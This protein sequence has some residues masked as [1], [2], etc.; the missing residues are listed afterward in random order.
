MVAC[1]TC[2]AVSSVCAQITESE[3]GNVGIKVGNATPLSTLSVATPG[4][5][6]VTV[7][8]SST[9]LYALRSYTSS[10]TS[11]SYG[12][13]GRALPCNDKHIGVY[14]SSSLSS[15][16][17]H[18]RAYGVLGTAGNATSGWNYGVFGALGGTN[19]GAAVLGTVE[20][21]T[22]MSWAVPGRYAGYF[23][24]PVH[25]TGEMTAS[26]FTVTS[27]ARLKREVRELSSSLGLLSQLVPVEY[28]LQQ[29]FPVEYSDTMQT[30]RAMSPASAEKESL[31][32]RYGLIAQ[33]VAE[34]FPDIVY[35]DGNGYLSIDYIGLIPLL[36]QSVKELNE[37]LHNS[38]E[39]LKE[40]T[41]SIAEN[42]Y[43]KEEYIGRYMDLCSTYIEKMDTYRRQLSKIASTSS[44]NELCK[45]IKSS[46]FI[47]SE[48][49]EFYAEFDDTFLQLF[50]TFVEDF[51]SLLQPQ[52]RIYPKENERMN[53]ELRIFALIRL[54]ITD[55][56]KIAH[57]LRYSVTTIY[58]YRTKVRNKAVG[59]RDELERMVAKIGKLN[60]YI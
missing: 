30:A 58:N 29:S 36:I 53:T 27:D 10:A 48:L 5:S 17:S 38:N 33:D 14:G 39:K 1:A 22:S 44:K 6:P 59:S 26:A 34:L 19:N 57:F 54:G 41:H 15:P 60:R 3:D 18:Y 49:K 52:E 40:A 56:V 12:L 35:E 2:M 47:E 42:S 21:S 25:S 28:K 8:I 46:K 4:D 9:N 51:N 20:S 23:V 43:L 16:S 50:P 11:W 13:Y 31:R 24:G 37:E 55:S 32:Y 7:D 45:Y